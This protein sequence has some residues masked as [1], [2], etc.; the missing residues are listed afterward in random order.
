MMRI[1]VDAGLCSGHGRCYV[2]SPN[3]FTADDEGYC[4]QRGSE[5]DVDERFAAEARIGV[6]SCP[7]GAMRILEDAPVDG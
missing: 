3:V 2:L 4:A 5:F 6:E 1:A 7:E